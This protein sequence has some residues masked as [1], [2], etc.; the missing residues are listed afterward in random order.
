MKQQL[1]QQQQ[2]QEQGRQ[3]SRAAVEEVR[4][5]HEPGIAAAAAAAK[6]TLVREARGGGAVA[7]ETPVVGANSGPA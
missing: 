5:G 3:V 2:E 4:N 6:E 1:Q 7:G